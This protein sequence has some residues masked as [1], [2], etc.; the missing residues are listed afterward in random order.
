MPRLV[1]Q[2]AVLMILMVMVAGGLWW[3]TGRVG[4]SRL[5]QWIGSNLVGVIQNYVN[6][7]LH[8]DYLDY[9]VPRS[10]VVENLEFLSD[11][12]PILTADRVYLQLAQTPT[13]GQPIRIERIT[14]DGLELRL[15]RQP[16]GLIGWRRFVK[17][18][19]LA[20]V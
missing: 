16:E 14:V 8:F 17:E 2:V 19:V 3:Y 10:V 7:R 1:R 9:Q 20:G 18:D 5:E 15:I 4:S 6:P 11:G 13:Q 12:T